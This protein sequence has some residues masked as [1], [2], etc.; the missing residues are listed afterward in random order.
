MGVKENNYVPALGFHFLT[1]LYDAIVR[2]TTRERRFKQALITQ[3]SLLPGQRVLDLACGTGTLSVWAKRRQPGAEIVGLDGDPAVLSIAE[4]KSRAAGVAITFHH[5]LSHELPYPNAHF[6]RI[7]TSLFF[8]HLLPEEKWRTA[9]DLLRVLKPGGELHVADWGKPANNVMRTLF[10]PVQWLDGFA[11]TNDN[12][13]GKLMP[14]FENCGFVNVSEREHFNTS[15][16]TLRLFS[17]VKP[18][19]H[20]ITEHPQT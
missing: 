4:A 1:P 12:L 16:G 3:A 19:K 13:Q 17:A 9:Q 8:H 7:L 15:L 11:N 6:D 5:G 14:M 2:I 10:L 20:N 18:L